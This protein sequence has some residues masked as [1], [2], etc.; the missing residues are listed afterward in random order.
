MQLQGAVLADPSLIRGEV[1]VAGSA[2][3]AEGT[4]FDALS[5]KAG[6][7]HC[8]GARTRWLS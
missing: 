2:A 4:L 1:Q 3:K 8:T 5:P 7:E 6:V